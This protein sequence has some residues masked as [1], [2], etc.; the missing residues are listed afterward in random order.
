MVVYS[1]MARTRR[2]S[3]QIK[4]ANGK[5]VLFTAVHWDEENRRAAVAQILR[6]DGVLKVCDFAAPNLKAKGGEE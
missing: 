4:D 1:A 2:Y 6:L 3:I 5:S